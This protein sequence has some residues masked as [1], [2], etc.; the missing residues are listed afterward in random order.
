MLCASGNNET[1]RDYES[2]LLTSDKMGGRSDPVSG[3]LVGCILAAT[4]L[5]QRG[6]VVRFKCMS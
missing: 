2:A 1:L 6:L 3:Q 5:A 4:L